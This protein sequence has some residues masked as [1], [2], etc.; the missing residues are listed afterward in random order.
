MA[1]EYVE[2]NSSWFRDID[3]ATGTLLALKEAGLGCLLISIS[4]FHNQRIPARKVKGAMAACAEAGLRVFP[5]VSELWPDME[6]MGL[7]KIHGPEEFR[8][9]FGEGYWRGLLKRFWLHLGGRAAYFYAGL[10]ELTPVETILEQSRGPCPELWDT[11]HFHLDLYG[12][13]VPGLCS[14]LAFP[15]R[16][17]GEQVPPE[18]YP[19]LCA[20]SQGGPARLL[21]LAREREFVPAGAYLNKCHLCL[22]MRSHLVKSGWPDLAPRGFYQ[23]LSVEAF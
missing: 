21:E 14:G 6:A 1:V 18:E 13:Y 3:S 11:G 10:F 2:T 23:N 8:A 15:A 17:L 22:E 5:W 7:E 9:R 19:A 20:L 16:L 4:P 12:N